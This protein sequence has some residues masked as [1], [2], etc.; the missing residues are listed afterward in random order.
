MVRGRSSILEF[1]ARVIEQIKNK[2][3]E[4]SHREAGTALALS[5]PG[6]PLS[7][8]RFRL[9]ALQVLVEPRHDLDEVAR[10]LAVVELL[11]QDAIPGVAARR[12]RA[13]EDE[14]EG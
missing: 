12:G 13:G 10:V 14:D 2:E 11:H 9:V 6:G 8:W 1:V 4:I 3:W 5:H 7:G